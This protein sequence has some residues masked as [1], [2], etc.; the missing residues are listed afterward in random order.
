MDAQTMLG[1]Q[2]ALQLEAQ[3]HQS[4][5]LKISKLYEP[6]QKY[7]V[8]MLENRAVLEE[9][10]TATEHSVMKQV[11]PLLIPTPIAEARA[12]VTKRLEFM[13]SKVKSLEAELHAL[14]EEQRKSK[15][16]FMALQQLIRQVQQQQSQKA[17]QGLQ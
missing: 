12:N 17:M 3:N 13:E 5:Q 2:H 1:A 4:I 8:Q 7:E 14:V 11:G 10:A 16:K 9:L 6:R 15:D